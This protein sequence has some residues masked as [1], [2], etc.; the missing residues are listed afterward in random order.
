MSRFVKALW[1]GLSVV[2]FSY[3]FSMAGVYWLPDF[4][5]NP[6]LSK[7]SKSD[8]GDAGSCGKYDMLSAVPHG[9]TCQT[10]YPGKGLKCYDNCSCKSEYS[11]TSKSSNLSCESEGCT[12][13]GVTKYKCS[14]CCGTSWRYYS[15][16]SS[17]VQMLRTNALLCQS[18]SSAYG[19]TL[20]SVIRTATCSEGGFCGICLSDKDKCEEEGKTWCSQTSVCVDTNEGGCCA[21]NECAS[22]SCVNNQCVDCSAY[23]DNDAYLSVEKLKD[24]GITATDATSLNK[25]CSQLGYDVAGAAETC[26]KKTYWKCTK[27]SASNKKV[28]GNTCIALSD[29][30]GDAPAAGCRC[31]NGSWEKD[32]TAYAGWDYSCNSGLSDICAGLQNVPSAS[33]VVTLPTE[34]SATSQRCLPLSLHCQSKGLIAAGDFVTCGVK[35]Y[36]KCKSCPSG[37]SVGL[38]ADKCDGQ[39]PETHATETACKKCPACAAGYSTTSKTV[40]NGYKLETQASNP[41]C[42]KLVE[43]KATCSNTQVKVTNGGSSINKCESCLNCPSGYRTDITSASCSS[44]QKFVK[45]SAQYQSCGKC[46]DIACDSGYQK[47]I[48]CNA[49]T[50]NTQKQVSN[51]SCVK[52]VAKTC[53]D[54]GYRSSIPSEQICTRFAY[55]SLTCYK[56][57]KTSTCAAGI[58][59]KENDAM[60]YNSSNKVVGFSYNGKD[61]TSGDG[62]GVTNGGQNGA[63]TSCPKNGFVIPTD[64]AMTNYINKIDQSTVTEGFKAAMTDSSGWWTSASCSGSYWT[65]QNVC[66]FSGGHPKDLCLKDCSSSALG[67]AAHGYET[68]EISGKKCDKV[69][70]DGATCYQCR[71]FTCDDYEAAIPSGQICTKITISGRTCYKDCKV[72]SCPVGFYN[73]PDDNQIYDSAGKIV[74]FYYQ[75]KYYILAALDRTGGGA[76][77]YEYAVNY[78]KRFGG[79]VPGATNMTRYIQKVD[80]AN[81]NEEEK[82]IIS[83]NIW[84]TTQK[85]SGIHP[86]VLSSGMC[87][88]DKPSTTPTVVCVRDCSAAATGCLVKGYEP[89]VPFGQVCKLVTLDDMTCYTNCRN[90]TCSDGGYYDTPQSGKTC[91]Q[92]SYADKNCYECYTSGSS[93]GSCSAGESSS[94]CLQMIPGL[95]KCGIKKCVRPKATAISNGTAFQWHCSLGNSNG[96]GGNSEYVCATDCGNC[97]SY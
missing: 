11:Y 19:T 90:R 87:W 85:C 78:C 17:L 74:G 88:S 21:D 59:R 41:L 29:C 15:P 32:C 73:N 23:D 70:V 12:I 22:G 81:F 50:H 3:T 46:E 95:P 10:K 4:L 57:C 25:G 51:P 52:C 31:N 97:G 45:G 7:P 72:S 75:N 91:T 36:G 48:T 66:G 35:K 6:S 5:D 27:C 63:L 92:V 28:C 64:V 56:D 18:L 9:A 67:C 89:E 68:R 16:S 79:Y 39:E 55:N 38:T 53:E 94:W 83:S 76:A 58:Y 49:S 44:G 33:D 2:V 69:E 1:L 60:L 80:Q 65:S 26:G 62:Y 82:Y 20:N 61:Y 43:C 71:D 30:C 93:G 34:K 40:N 86:Y 24:M 37:Y 14:E 42:T 13:N 54:Y 96:Y 84:W 77:S 47:G 8:K